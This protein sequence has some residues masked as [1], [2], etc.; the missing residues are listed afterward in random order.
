MSN[1]S[2]KEAGG[3]LADAIVSVVVALKRKGPL[4]TLHSRKCNVENLVENEDEM[5]A[6]AT[7]ENCSSPSLPQ[8]FIRICY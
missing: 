8:G 1:R 4:F 7:D 6:R 2:T 5:R 3:N